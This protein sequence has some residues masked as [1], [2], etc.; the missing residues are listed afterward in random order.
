MDRL[1]EQ[2]SVAALIYGNSLSVQS[3]YR[4]GCFSAED[5]ALCRQTSLI[6]ASEGVL[7][8]FVE[9]LFKTCLFLV[10]TI[11]LKFKMH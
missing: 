4:I 3:H 11:K 6:T 10:F 8:A 1:D 9:C 7:K 5:T 2:I